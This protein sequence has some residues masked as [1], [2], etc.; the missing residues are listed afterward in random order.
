MPHG[1][2]HAESAG[3]LER[4][5]QQRTAGETGESSEHVIAAGH[6]GG[7]RGGERRRQEADAIEEAAILVIQERQAPLDAGHEAA[8][9]IWLAGLTFEGQDAVVDDRGEIDKR[10][11]ACPRRDQLDGE[12]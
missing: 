10:E 1:L 12:R 8:V 5:L 9:V 4:G 2:Q 3:R 6:G 11:A 7:S